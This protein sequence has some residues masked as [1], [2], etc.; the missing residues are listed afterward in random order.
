MILGKAFAGHGVDNAQRS[1]AEFIGRYQ[2]CAGVEADIRGA[3]DERVIAEQRVLGGVGDDIGI[4]AF[5]GMVAEGMFT[6]RLRGVQP[7]T[8]FKPLAVAVDQRNDLDRRTEQLGGHLHNLI[9]L[10]FRSG[11]QD[12]VFGEF[13]EARGF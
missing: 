7:I 9:E 2:R 6:L 1:E 12:L 4:V 11:I 5:D 8:R 3:G 10:L 13:T